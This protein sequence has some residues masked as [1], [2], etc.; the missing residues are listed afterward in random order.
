MLFVVILCSRRL[1]FTTD[2]Q[3]FQPMATLEYNILALQAES[4]TTGQAKAFVRNFEAFRTV[5]WDQSDGSRT[6]RS[7]A[8]LVLNWEA[9]EVNYSPI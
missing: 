7:L 9:N 5:S 4:A 8:N 1:H 3:N 2:P 6:I